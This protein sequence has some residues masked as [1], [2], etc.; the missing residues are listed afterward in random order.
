MAAQQNSLINITG[1][2]ITQLESTVAA[3]GK[4][5]KIME[6]QIGQIAAQQ[7]AQPKTGHFPSNTEVNPKN[8]YFAIQTRSG[9]AYPSPAKEEEHESTLEQKLV[10]A[11]P[12]ARSPESCPQQ[13]ATE[14]APAHPTTSHQSVCAPDL[15]ASDPTLACHPASNQAEQAAE[16]SA[17][18]LAPAS[19]H[20]KKESSAQQI[21]RDLPS[22]RE[23][24]REAPPEANRRTYTPPVPFPSRLVK[25]KYDEEFARFKEIFQNVEINLPLFDALRNMPGYMKFLKDALA[26]KKKLGK[27]EK[28]TLSEECSAVLQRKLPLK[29]KDPGSFTLECEIA[30]QTFPNVLCDLG[31]SI[32][33]MPLNVFN[34][35]HLGKMKPTKISLMMADRSVT[36]P[37]GIVEDV[38]V[39]IR[40]FVFSADF[41]ILDILEF[42]QQPLI[43]GRPF[44][45]TGR[46]L[47]DVQEGNLTFRVNDEELKI[48]IYDAIKQHDSGKPEECYSITT[49]AAAHVERLEGT[50]PIEDAARRKKWTRHGTPSVS[51]KFGGGPLP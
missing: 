12:T 48:S 14:Q 38:L 21:P 33:L 45:A 8:Q 41:V 36:Y 19:S 51:F 28:I 34:R 30:E 47:I 39:R 6:N 50:R 40:D 7:N 11:S 42:K 35:L 20:A 1:Q 3:M 26:S 32:N 5:M 17:R 25:S 10:T 4:H 37:K 13:L 31:A 9:R 43:L 24:D 49:A 16:K 44:L 2:R 29:Q 22:D 15:F 23:V 27:F 46:A 18:E